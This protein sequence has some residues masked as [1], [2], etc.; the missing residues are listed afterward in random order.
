VDNGVSTPDV[1]NVVTPSFPVYLIH[2]KWSL[3]KLDNFLTNYGSVGFLRI[4]YDKEG[5]ETNRNI[6]ILPKTSFTKL[7]EDGFNRHQ[8]GRSF[9]ISQYVL[10]EN[11][12]PGKDHTNTLFVPVPKGLSASDDIVVGIIN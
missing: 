2:S 10:R 4:V 8:Y 3:A 9:V 11:N 7:C 6:A 12:F 1:S 5:N